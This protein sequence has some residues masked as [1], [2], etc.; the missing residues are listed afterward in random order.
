M[1]TY[2][3]TGASGAIGSALVPILLEE[4][5]N[6]IWLLLRANSSDEL[7][8]RMETLF[9]FWRI[10]AG[11]LDKRSRVRAFRGDTGRTR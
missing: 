9:A 6:D 1:N 2:F 11:D 4:A 10:D 3:L 8:Q 7:V 5:D